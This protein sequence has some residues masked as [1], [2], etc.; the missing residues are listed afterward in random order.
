MEYTSEFAAATENITVFYYGV[1][2][3]I[4]VYHGYYGVYFLHVTQKN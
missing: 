1:L 2:R 4:T 3:C